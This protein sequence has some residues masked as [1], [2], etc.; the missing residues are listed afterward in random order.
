M[1]LYLDEDIA[2]EKIP[3]LKMLSLKIDELEKEQTCY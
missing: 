3:T 1:R 2:I